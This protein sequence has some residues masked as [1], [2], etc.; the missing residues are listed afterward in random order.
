ML[1]YDLDAYRGIRA[2]LLG[3]PLCSLVITEIFV[4]GKY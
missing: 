4:Y 2:I 1:N 3:V